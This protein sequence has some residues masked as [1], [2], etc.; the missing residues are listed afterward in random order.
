MD[1]MSDVLADSRRLRTLNIVDD[2]TRAYLAIEVDIARVLDEVGHQRAWPSE[3]PS[4][5]GLRSPARPSTSGP[6]SGARKCA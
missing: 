2:A 4:T 6:T 3:S 5:T 1:V